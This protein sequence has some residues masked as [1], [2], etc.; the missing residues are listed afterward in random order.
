M[1]NME[2]EYKWDGN[3]PRA[4]ARAQQFLAQLD[5]AVLPKYLKIKDVYL[6]HA[7]GDLSAQKIALRVRNTDGKWEAT[8]KTRTEIKSGKAV[9]R[10][11][12][13]PLP[14]VT[15]LAQALR[16]LTRQKKWGPIPLTGL[17]EKFSLVN[18][19]TLYVFNYDGAKLEMALDE[20]CLHVLGRR[21]AF[22]E[23]EVELKK[24]TSQTLDRF[25]FVFSKRTHLKK[26]KISKVKTAETFLKFWK[27]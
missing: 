2:I 11:E 6:D 9:R 15:H 23:I 20:V 25:A 17:E 19:R 22:K 26:A 10:E 1:R 3:T 4:F 12:T 13:L 27:K 24:G 5:R 21:V 14:G 7:S 18:K 16:V 8:Y